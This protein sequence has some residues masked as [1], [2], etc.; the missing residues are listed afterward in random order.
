MAISVRS[1]LTNRRKEEKKVS[2]WTVDW[3]AWHF[4]E[5]GKI[6][7]ISY[8]PIKFTVEAA[9]FEEAVRIAESKAPEELCRV[10]KEIPE[11]FTATSNSVPHILG[12]KS[13]EGAY[14]EISKAHTVFGEQITELPDYGSFE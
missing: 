11:E 13:E 8:I 12:L 7:S 10:Q 14:H 2:R 1:E 9:S 4:D 5:N 3:E 6:M